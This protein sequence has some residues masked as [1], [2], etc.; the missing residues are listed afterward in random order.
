LGNIGRSTFIYRIKQGWKLEDALTKPIKAGSRI[1][2]VKCEDHL[3][4]R[5]SSLENMCKAYGIAR[6]AFM[7]RINNGWSLEDALTTPIRSKSKF[8]SID[9]TGK[10]Y[11]SL[12]E[13]CKHYNISKATLYARL[14]RGMSLEDALTIPVDK[15]GI[16]DYRDPSGNTYNNIVEI[17]NAYGISKSTVYLRLHKG[18]SLEDALT[19]PVDKIGIKDYRDPSGNTYNNIDEIC[20]AYGISKS[21]VYL[22]L[23]KGMSLEDAIKTPVRNVVGCRDH[24]G[25]KY[26]NVEEMCKY[27]NIS[28]SALY[29]RINKGMSLEDALTLPVRKKRKHIK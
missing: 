5:Y 3:K 7:S 13:M 15:I 8:E 1:G 14:N 18:M 24:L 26:N 20:N 4:N 10:E 27:Y 17:C 23:R 25:N 21:T 16:K 9:H 2:K 29:E 12:D 28:K 19:L 22:R 6:E 11:N